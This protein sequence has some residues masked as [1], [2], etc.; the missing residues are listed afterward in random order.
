[1]KNKEE[2]DRDFLVNIIFQIRNYA[3]EN[4]MEPDDTIKTVAENMIAMLQ[5]ATFNGGG[6]N[7]NSD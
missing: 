1:M 6:E 7:A 4:E 5:I 3:I 2:S